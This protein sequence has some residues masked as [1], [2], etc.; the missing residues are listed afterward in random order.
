MK[1]W[2]LPNSGLLTGVD[3]RGL[4]DRFAPEYS[5]RISIQV[6]N[7]Q[8]MWSALF[9]YQRRPD[10]EEFPDVIE[11]P[12]YWTPLFAGMEI[13]EPLT[14][15]GLKF[16]PSEWIGP[17]V[18]HCYR[19]RT[20]VPYSVPWL[21]DVSAL[22]YRVDH[23]QE[24]SHKPDQLLATWDGFLEACRLL[25]ARRGKDGDYW[26]IE[27]SNL[28][29]TVNI[30]DILPSI[31]NN[32]GSLFTADNSRSALHREETLR[33]IESY[34]DLFSKGHMPLLREKGSRGTMIEGK[35][36]MCISRRQADAVFS[37]EG[38]ETFPLKTLS[39]PG[40]LFGSHSF[41]SSYNLAVMGFS[42]EK[43]AAGGLLTRL[44]QQQAQLE[45]AKTVSAFPCTMAA[46]EKFIFSA[47]GR[48]HTYAHI[49]GDAGTVPAFS[50]TGTYFEILDEALD[51][52]C[53]KIARGTYSAA[54]FREKMLS[55]S[56][57]MDYLI[58]LYGG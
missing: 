38:S 40:G 3:F 7:R 21:M 42:K 20:K 15:I 8:R 10:D 37:A 12:H 2:V 32:G 6:V 57:E 36:S 54:L 27:N 55:V 29:G 41:L 47:P 24:V 31:W 35:A 1:I 58:A 17:L 51:S 19:R 52:L 56:K 39:V 13:F 9:N 50:I 14:E 49:V 48:V 33:G 26:P 25:R 11:I 4:L 22:H 46:F 18:E 45:Y 28:R 16:D 23:L 43:E 53:G 5:P 44:I 34:L 30:R